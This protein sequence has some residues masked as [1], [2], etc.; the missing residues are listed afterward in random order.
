MSGK[1]LRKA[2]NLLPKENKRSDTERVRWVK[3]QTKMLT[4]RNCAHLRKIKACLL[5]STYQ[6]LMKGQVWYGGWKNYRVSDGVAVVQI[7]SG[8]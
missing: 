6:L 8:Q 7:F 5:P 2:S 1:K 3:N 4:I